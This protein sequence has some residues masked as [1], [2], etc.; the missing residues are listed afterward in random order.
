MTGG[1]IDFENGG[2]NKRLY[3][4]PWTHAMDKN[5]VEHDVFE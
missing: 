4:L 2:F 1:V 3:I 5:A